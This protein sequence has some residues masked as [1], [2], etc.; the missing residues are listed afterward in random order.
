MRVSSRV[1]SYTQDPSVDEVFDAIVIGSG[2]GGMTAAAL[3]ARQAGQRV[4]VLERHYTPGGFTHCF[5]RP[6]YEWDVGVHYIGQVNSPES[7]VRAA[8]DHLTEG[9]LG[10]H[11]MPEV[12]DRLLLGDQEYEFLSHAGPFRAR[13]EERFPSQ[14]RAID[15]YFRAVRS[16]ARASGIYFASKALPRPLERLAGGLMRARFLRHSDRTTAEVL[17]SLGCSAELAGVLTGQWGDYGLP[18][19]QSSFGVHALIVE[20]YLEGAAYPVGGASAIFASILPAVEG[21]G[22]KV[23]VSADVQEVVL[24]EYGRAAGVRMADGR[25][26]RAARV[27]SDAGA[28]NTYLRLLPRGMAERLGVAPKLNQVPASM[29]HISLYVG[30]KHTAEELGLHGGNLWVCSGPDHDLNVARSA[31]SPE[32]PPAVLFIS[33]PPPRT[34]P[35]PNA[36]RGVPPSKSWRPPPMRGSKSGRAHAGSAAAPITTI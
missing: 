2:M 23:L 36:F 14:A 8:F 27:I 35:S 19:G 21:T 4:L 32:H 7:S 24:D 29:S 31:A 18:P 3:L 9:R 17:R 5:R 12:Y 28:A 11:P 13:L 1:S 34:R 33:F 15:A 20:H 22:G 30:L 26:F 10:W 16:A 6:G 25:Q